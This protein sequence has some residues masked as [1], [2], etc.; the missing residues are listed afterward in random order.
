MEGLL[1]I[2]GLKYMKIQKAI[3]DIRRI[4]MEGDIYE[5][6]AEESI[7]NIGKRIE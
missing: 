5:K 1:Y 6:V 3:I 7:I 4:I 2:D